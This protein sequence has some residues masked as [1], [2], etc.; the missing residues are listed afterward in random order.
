LA[1]YSDYSKTTPRPPRHKPVPAGVRDGVKHARGYLEGVR[2]SGP[3]M[4]R[5]QQLQAAEAWALVAVAEAL[6]ARL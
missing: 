1:D 6:A 4:S 5:D 3:A 2:D